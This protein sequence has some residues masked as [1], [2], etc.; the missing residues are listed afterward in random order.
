MKIKFP[1]L[2]IIIFAS[3]STF[4]QNSSFDSVWRKE[5][6][7]EFFSAQEI[8]YDSC[9]FS[10][11]LLKIVLDKNS[12]ISTVQFSD[13]TDVAIKNS[14]LRIFKKAGKIDQ[15]LEMEARKSHIK[16][17]NVILPVMV[18]ISSETCPTVIKEISS[19]DHLYRFNNN[20][21][22]GN[23][24]FRKSFVSITYVTPGKVPLTMPAQKI[25]QKLLD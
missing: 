3:Q 18:T 10:H 22:K 2:L 6:Y 8:T 24:L 20:Y 25:E 13:S 1:S 15:L 17:I 16:N 12:V 9:Y 5:L 21:L 19:D 11:F 23:C 14:F 4:G 7:R